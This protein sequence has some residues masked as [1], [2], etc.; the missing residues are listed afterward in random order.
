MSD[1]KTQILEATE[2]LLAKHGFDRLSMQMVAKEAGV[3]AGTIYRYFSDKD[4]LL[5]QLRNHVVQQCAAKM[6]E[7][8]SDNMSLKQQFVTLW[9]NAWQL[10]IS[11]DDNAINREQFD[12]LPYQNNGEQKMAERE[13]FSP[14]HQLFQTG[15]ANG[16]FKP[17]TTDVL[18]GIGLEPAVCL[19][20]KQVKGVITLDA[21]AI[22]D[23]IDACWDAICLHKESEQSQ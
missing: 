15:I 12:S 18:S 19:A 14:I 7:G 3:A 2:R 10:T 9:L 20:R 21:S 23:A 13:A 16:T 8:H 1:K 6:L 5:S 11:R 17:L 4:D 22:D